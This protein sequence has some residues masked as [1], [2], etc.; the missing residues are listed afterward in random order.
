MN[1]LVTPLS[2]KI[3]PY[4]S[5]TILISAVSP[6]QIAMTSVYHLS[7]HIPSVYYGYKQ[8]YHLLL[9]TKNQGYQLLLLPLD[10]EKT[11][12]CGAYVTLHLATYSCQQQICCHQTCN[13]FP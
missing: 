12:C 1:N 11:T 5:F 9:G 2:S 4:S 13:S 7:V 10:D 6:F 3:L 8:G